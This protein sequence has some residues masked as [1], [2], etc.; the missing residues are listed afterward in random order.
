MYTDILYN[1][2]A[3]FSSNNRSVLFMFELP[4]FIFVCVRLQVKV[5]DEPPR[6]DTI[7]AVRALGATEDAIDALTTEGDAHT[8]LSNMCDDVPIPDEQQRTQAQI[9]LL[10]QLYSDLEIP[11]LDRIIP[12]TKRGC[13]LLLD[14]L[15]ERNQYK[16]DHATPTDA[17]LKELK[18]KGVHIVPPTKRAASSILNVLRNK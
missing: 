6:A 17:Q 2:R 13:S 11:P 18:R 14:T 8:L 7:E 4:E 16:K 10:L 5:E 3:R 12:E 9:K 15:V 1:V